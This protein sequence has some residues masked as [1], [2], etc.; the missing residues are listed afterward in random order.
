[1]RD[2]KGI[3]RQTW[4]RIAA[5]VVVLTALGL[6]GWLGAPA[7][8]A[9][10]LQDFSD[11]LAPHRRA[12][13]APPV[14]ALGFVLLGLAMVPVLL[15]IAATGVAFGPWLGPLYAMAG[16]LA[17]ASIGFAIGRW[18]GLGRI[19]RVG[20]TRV[21]R[22]VASLERNG[23]LAVFFLRKI[24]APFLIVNIV[25]GASRVSYRDFVVGTF[26]GMTAVVVGLAGFGSQLLHVF[27]SPSPM[28]VLS[29]LVFIGIPLTLAWLI[30]RVLRRPE[31]TA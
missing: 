11:W 31:Q 7:T 21:S 28:T 2:R 16:C 26:L 8:T 12:W 27:H 5:V 25:A 20:G 23:T 24:P 6:I 18:T 15:L 17:S 13:Y 9:M 14:V 29:A 3:N 22:L 19:Q 10:K 30:N 1:V 4:I